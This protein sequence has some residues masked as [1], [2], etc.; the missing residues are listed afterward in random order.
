MDYIIYHQVKP[1]VDC[2]DGI[3]AAWVA[4]KVYLDA[5]IIGAVYQSPLSIQPA[6][7]DRLIIVD[8]SFSHEVIE[9]WIRRGV[10]VYVIDHHKT[11]EAELSRFY[12]ES[13]KDALIAESLNDEWGIE[14][15]QDECG[16]TLAWKR[17]FTKPMPAFLEFVRKRDLWLDCELFTEPVPETLIVHEA[18]ATLRYEHKGNVFEVYDMLAGLD[19]TQLLELCNTIG[20]PKVQEKRN[21]VESIASRHDWEPFINP[22]DETETFIPV[23]R[24]AKDGSEDRFTSDVCMKLYSQFPDADFV[25]CITSDGSWSLRSDSK[26]NNTDVGAIA[27]ALGGGGH[28][29]AAGY[30]PTR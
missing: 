21:K 15:D 14:F 2:P 18:V 22:L 6:K 23:V 4:S 9:G 1:G 20:L 8:F 19:R 7:G 24:L 17:F 11:A 28:R 30:R 16:A 12:V 29:N 3:A 10:K 27:K 26:G 5:Q 25:A 13:F